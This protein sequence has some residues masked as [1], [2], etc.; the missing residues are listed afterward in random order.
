M[1]AVMASAAFLRAP[2]AAAATRRHRRQLVV[3]AGQGFASNKPAKAPSSSKKQLKLARYL[4][5]DGTPAQQGAAAAAPADGWVEM[6][7]V[8][9]ETTF[10]SKP[11]K[12]LILATGRA[13]CLFKVNDR[14]YA[15]DANS[16]AYK[17]PLADASILS[18][19][20][21]P[22]VEVPLDGT[23]YDLATGKVLS[24]CP[25]NNLTR[26]ILGGLKDKTEP[27]DLPV[28]PVE[29]RGGKVFVKF[30]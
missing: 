27:I 2:A 25:K 17:Y 5:K 19:K 23:V 10:L 14:I 6:P 24:W 13:V 7:G 12:P 15:S 28:Y 30:I 22:A 26:K 8:D 9:A 16:T 4:E 11:I 20:G 1:S 18:V 3:A 21:A 29:V